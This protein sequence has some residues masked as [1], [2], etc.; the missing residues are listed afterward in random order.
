[1]EL[2]KLI[3]TCPKEHFQRFF[4]TLKFHSLWIS[5]RHCATNFRD[6]CKICM[7]LSGGTFWKKIFRNIFWASSGKFQ[8][9]DRKKIS[10]VAKTK[11]YLSSWK[12]WGFFVKK[13]SDFS[14][15]GTLLDIFWTFAKKLT[16]LSKLQ[17]TCP[18][19]ISKKSSLKKIKDSTK[20]FWSFA[21]KN[22]HSYNCILC[23]LSEIFLNFDFFLNF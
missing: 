12:I 20:S 2:S 17:S 1:M 23:F 10:K 22:R 15:F 14:F 7:L 3:S 18:E 5:F 16:W 13:N 21:E 19:K 6:G 9:F 8:D 4:F 11:I